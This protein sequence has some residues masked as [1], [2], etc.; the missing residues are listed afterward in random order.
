LGF[1]LSPEH[2]GRAANR[3]TA[4]AWRDQAAHPELRTC[5]L[6]TARFASGHDAQGYLTPGGW[7]GLQTA[8]YP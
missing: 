8:S 6:P 1:L 2:H 3:Y 4:T 7:A 5:S